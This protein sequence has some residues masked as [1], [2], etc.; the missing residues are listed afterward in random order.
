MFLWLSLMGT[1]CSFL[2]PKQS[3]MKTAV[4]KTTTRRTSAPRVYH[5][6]S[7]GWIAT[8]QEESIEATVEYS[9]ATPVVKGRS[10][11]TRW[12]FWLLILAGVTYLG[13]W[14]LVFK[15]LK[16]LREKTHALVTVVKGVDL[17]KEKA[18]EDPKANDV[19]ALKTIL[20]AQ[21]PITKAEVDQ[22]RNGG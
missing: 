11:W 17:F 22:I 14:P 6:E 7:G 13:L 16:K 4:A 19:T 3:V 10:I 21:D 1:G 9:K 12:W 18:A 15:L 5:S 8:G 2:T 20:K